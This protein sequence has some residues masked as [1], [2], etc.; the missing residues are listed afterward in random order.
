MQQIG[1]DK[2]SLPEVDGLKHLVLCI[3]YF[4]KL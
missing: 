4:S 2:C 1:I 3:G